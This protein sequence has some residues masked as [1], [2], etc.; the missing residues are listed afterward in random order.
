MSNFRTTY[1][2]FLCVVVLMAGF[3]AGP[4]LWRLWRIGTDPVATPGRVV[5]I[6]CP[7]HGRVDY[8]FDIDGTSHSGANHLIDGIP[9]PQFRIGQKVAVYY[10]KGAPGNNYAL[11]PDG[12]EGNRVRTA[13]FTGIAFC[14]GF[15]ALGPPFLAWVWILFSRLAARSR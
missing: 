15:I 8:A 4:L 11:Y 14:A 13:L 7:N 2:A 3:S 6:D 9:C 12:T 10:E 1:L 5:G